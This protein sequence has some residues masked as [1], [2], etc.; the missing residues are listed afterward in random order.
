MAKGRKSLPLLKIIGGVV[1]L[2]VIGS[3]LIFW[4]KQRGAKQLEQAGFEASDVTG[5]DE[6]I[7]SSW[8]LVQ[9][10]EYQ[11]Q[12]KISPGQT[13]RQDAHLIEPAGIEITI[14]HYGRAGG[15]SPDAIKLKHEHGLADEDVDIQG[16]V[17]ITGVGA[18]LIETQT[19]AAEAAGIGLWAIITNYNRGRY[20][21]TL[22]I[23]GGPG[24]R[25]LIEGILNTLTCEEDSIFDC[26]IP[27]PEY[28]D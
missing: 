12:F 8:K 25:Q 20:Q 9:D 27:G 10:D 7:Y 11:I 5:K 21:Q 15:Q 28:W 1:V 22:M 17:S 4:Q 24:H 13:Y 14:G 23:K 19:E 26:R 6:N 2:L 16:Y 3:G 18:D